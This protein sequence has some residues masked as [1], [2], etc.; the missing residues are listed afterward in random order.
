MAQRLCGRCSRDQPA[1]CAES[2]SASAGTAAAVIVAVAVAVSLLLRVLLLS[3]CRSVAPSPTNFGMVQAKVLLAR[4]R[5]LPLQ[6]V[7]AVAPLES[8]FRSHVHEAVSQV[9]QAA[10]FAIPKIKTS[11]VSG[12][13]VFPLQH[14]R[15]PCQTGGQGNFL[16][17]PIQHHF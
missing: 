2:A 8:A 9:C 10:R 1:R 15:S 12:A 14:S 5:R 17:P 13:T 16:C 6:L 3:P 7:D 4:M 11:Q